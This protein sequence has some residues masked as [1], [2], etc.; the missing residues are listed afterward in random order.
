MQIINFIGMSRSGNHAVIRWILGHFQNAKVPIHFYNNTTPS[1]LEHL[2][3]IHK[4]LNSDPGRVLLVSFEDVSLNEKFSNLSSI[5]THNIILIRDPLNLFASRLEGLGPNR[6]K[7]LDPRRWESGDKSMHENL[8]RN[9]IQT[10]KR[11]LPNQINLYLNHYEEFK[12]KTSFL[13][14]KIH[15]AYNDWVRDKDYRSKIISN[16]NV[17]F[18]DARFNVKAGSSFKKLGNTNEDYLSRWKLYWNDPLYQDIRE[19]ET[20]RNISSEFGVTT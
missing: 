18:T 13:Q 20:L 9:A 15:I 19:N 1:F 4:D 7:A 10:T 3:F 2:N 11:A 14:N 5:A 8:L 16:F 6:G 12:N 17:K